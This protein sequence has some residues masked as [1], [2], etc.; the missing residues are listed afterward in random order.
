MSAFIGLEDLRDLEEAQCIACRFRK[1]PDDDGQHAQ[2]FPMCY[3]IEAAA[4]LEEEHP[5]LDEDEF[6]VLACTK[7]RPGDPWDFV[8]DPGQEGL[9]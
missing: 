8:E 7:Y 2:E 9:F 4:M 6:G 1:N 5:A 3:E